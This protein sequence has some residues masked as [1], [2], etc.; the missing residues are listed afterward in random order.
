MPESAGWEDLHHLN[1]VVE[2]DGRQFRARCPDFD[3]LTTGK[4]AN[5]A[6]E[7]MWNMIQ[8]YLALARL[9]TWEDYF[10]GFVEVPEEDD[11]T[12]ASS[13]NPVIN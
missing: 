2:W 13:D 5:E 7:A 6:R 12:W 11:T 3:L 9:E 1:V 4:T 10:N 8:E